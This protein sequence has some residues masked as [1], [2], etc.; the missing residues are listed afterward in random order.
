MEL[1]D[2]LVKLMADLKKDTTPVVQDL[3]RSALGH[4]D[5]VTRAEFDAQSRV[6]EKAHQMLAT[7]EARLAELQ[8]NP[9]L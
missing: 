5:L 7:L 4:M 1:V 3:L 9:E 8:K 2:N 6:L